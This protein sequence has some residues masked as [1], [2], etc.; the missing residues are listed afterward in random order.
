VGT[1]VV[2]VDVSERRGLDVVALGPGPAL[3]APP[4]RRQTPAELGRW[5]AECRPA[6]VAI[7]SP[8][9]WGTGGTRESERALAGL[10]LP[11]FRTPSDPRRRRHPFYN[12]MRVGHEAFRAAAEAGYPSY[13]GGPSAVGC[14]LEVFP[15]A[16]AVA[17]AGVRPP[18]GTSRR[19]PAKRAWRRAVLEA[20]GLDS[21]ELRSLDAVDAALAALTALLVAGGGDWFAVGDAADGF[22]VLPGIRPDGPYP[23][24]GT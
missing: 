19:G 11:C 13:R 2:G 12:W 8:P 7:D 16:S 3:V 17:L 23:K 9:G 22:I 5:L 18:P 21:S 6:V 24:S 4:R 20:A 10:G 1:L 15:H 14:A